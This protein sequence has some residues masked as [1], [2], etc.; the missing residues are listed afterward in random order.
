MVIE[1]SLQY[2]C[3]FI[4]P[5]LEYQRANLRVGGGGERMDIEKDPAGRGLK[6]RPL[7][8]SPSTGP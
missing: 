7:A 5:F 3:K 4:T 2:W 6:G 1:I 8:W